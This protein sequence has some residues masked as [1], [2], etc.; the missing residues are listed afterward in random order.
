MRTLLIDGTNLFIVNYA[1]NPTLDMNG[2]PSGGI[3]GTLKSLRRIIGSLK[4]SKVIFVWDGAQGSAKKRK[5]FRDYKQGRRP[6][7]IAGRNYAFESIDKAIENK[8][9]QTKILQELIECLPVLQIV[10]DSVEADDAIAYLVNSCEYF[11]HTSNIIATCDKDFYQ[12]INSKTVIYNPIKKCLVTEQSLIEETGYHPKNWLFL[13]TI[14]GDT[15]DNIEGVRNFG[16]KTVSKLFPVKEDLMLEPKVIEETYKLQCDLVAQDMGNAKWLEK[17]KVLFENIDLIRRN[18]E[19][20]SLKDVLMNASE[21]DK[22]TYQVT[23]FTPILN[24]PKFY[25]SL[26]KLGGLGIPTNFFDEFY[27]LR[28]K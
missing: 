19:L 27:S 17:Y 25:V 20:M 7:V 23:N 4:P 3:A 18:W 10:T 8:I 13:K 1:A 22:L 2:V 11:N 26:M 16:P 21:K 12:L 6:R 24:K 9:W 15:S 28:Q 14:N 5:L